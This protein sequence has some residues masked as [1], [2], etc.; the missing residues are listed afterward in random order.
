MKKITAFALL[1]ALFVLFNNTADAQDTTVKKNIFDSIKKKGDSIRF[2]ADSIQKMSNS[3]VKKPTD[4]NGYSP[5]ETMSLVIII[6]FFLIM[7]LLLVMFFRHLKVNN[8]R[9]GYQSIKLIGLILIFPGVCILAT[10][11]QGI[12]KSETLAA[13][14]GTIA[15]YVLSR[16]DDSKDNINAAQKKTEEDLQAKIKL[17]EDTIKTIKE[18]NPNLVL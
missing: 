15:G 7:A 17:L 9:I 14:F 5:T 12:L 13:L 1:T 2:Y 16:E 18:K 3:P 4:T 10:V 8:Q 6:A 11:G